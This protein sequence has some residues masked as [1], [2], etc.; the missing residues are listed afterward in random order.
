MI[1]FVLAHEMGHIHIGN[2]PASA[3]D[4]KVMVRN[5]QEKDL[6]WACPEMLSSKTRSVQETE[7]KADQY[8]AGL[9]SQVL[10][11]EGALRVPLLWY[12]LGAQTYLVYS[13]NV[14]AINAV[15]ETQS[16][17]FRKAM[18]IQLGADLYSQLIAQTTGP[19][20]G[21]HVMYRPTHPATVERVRLFLQRVVESP[22]SYHHGQP[23]SFPELLA[24]RMV[25]EPACGELKRK[26]GIQ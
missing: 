13:L 11:P 8:A 19:R 17:Y 12:E 4:E 18:Q 14:D 21:F 2:D 6:Q 16:N 3:D 26:Y 15:K 24:M 7:M 23:S 5:A 20:G 25:I 22:Y 9:I 1:A 10:F